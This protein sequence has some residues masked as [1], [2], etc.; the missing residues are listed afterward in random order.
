[1]DPITHNINELL[2]LCNIQSEGHRTHIINKITEALQNDKQALMYLKWK[3]QAVYLY[4]GPI[5]DKINGVC[6]AEI[7]NLSLP[8]DKIEFTTLTEPLIL[9]AYFKT[10]LEKDFSALIKDPEK[11]DRYKELTLKGQFRSA[12]KEA[13][14]LFLATRY[15]TQHLDSIEDV[16][17][18]VVLEAV[19][20][21]YNKTY[22]NP[23]ILE[24]IK[25]T[26]KNLDPSK[27]SDVK[28]AVKLVCALKNKLEIKTEVSEFFKTSLT[29]TKKYNFFDRFKKWLNQY[30]PNFLKK[31]LNLLPKHDVKEYIN[32]LT[33]MGDGLFGFEFPFAIPDIKGLLYSLDPVKNRITDLDLSE[34]KEITDAEMQFLLTFRNLRKITLGNEVKLPAKFNEQMN[35]IIIIRPELPEKPKSPVEEK[36]EEPQAPSVDVEKDGEDA[37]AHG[38]AQ[39]A[40]PQ[41]TEAPPAADA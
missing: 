30:L 13:A 5:T 40:A 9:P 35:K 34:M 1:M 15:G 19:T 18:E 21:L 26:L 25:N 29:H 23:S 4:G 7:H 28:Y 8:E 32:L 38:D 41:S 31:A 22:L 20:Q 33:P 14:N 3:G 6:L 37:S 39:A 2:D 16:S 27:L 11:A 12:S 24:I 17:K 10:L 36:K